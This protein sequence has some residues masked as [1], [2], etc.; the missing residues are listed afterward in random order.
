MTAGQEGKG[1]KEGRERKGRMYK[2]SVS[3]G[4]MTVEEKEK[5]GRRG[6]G[7]RA[8]EEGQGEKNRWK[9]GKYGGKKGIEEDGKT[10]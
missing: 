9:A 1:R 2:E 5:E 7:G 3:L 8:K 4:G 6:E 10:D